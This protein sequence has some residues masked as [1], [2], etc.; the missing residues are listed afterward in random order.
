MTGIP[1]SFRPLAEH[2]LPT[3]VNWF[4]EP[5]IARWWDQPAEI[6]SVRTKYL[7]RI[8]HHEPT[9]MWI[10]E[11]DGDACGLF[12]SYLHIDD[13][14]HDA[15]VG[16]ER[17]VGIDYLVAGSHRGRGLG[18]EVLRAFGFWALAH[19]RGADCCVA[20]PAQAN[21][22]SWRALEHGGFTRVGACEPPDEPVAYVYVLQRDGA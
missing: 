22:A 20:T 16:I 19:H 9:L 8:E 18:R 2:D 12:Q 1:I 10:A 4:A 17:A 11:V 15:C 3:L 14:E 21:T 13:P 7:P 5:E 6:D